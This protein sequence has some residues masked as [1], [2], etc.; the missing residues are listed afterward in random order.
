MVLVR[1]VYEVEY[2]QRVSA[3][4]ICLLAWPLHN[5]HVET[6]AREVVVGNVGSVADVELRRK[7][8]HRQ[9]NLH[10]VHGS[11]KR[12]GVEVRYEPSLGIS[13]IL[14]AV[15]VSVN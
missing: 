7:R 15:P 2:I 12:V 10:E 3:Q 6:L 11:A 8:E 14:Q 4:G 13:T 9:L 5:I 1:I